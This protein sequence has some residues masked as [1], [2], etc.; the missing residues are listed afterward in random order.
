MNIKENNF[1][2]TFFEFYEVDTRVGNVREDDSRLLDALPD[3][4]IE[5]LAEPDPPKPNQMLLF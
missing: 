5:E 3:Q 2:E 1:T 4:Q